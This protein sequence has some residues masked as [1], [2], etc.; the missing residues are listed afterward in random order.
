MVHK[1][2]KVNI[3]SEVPFSGF[4]LSLLLSASAEAQPVIQGKLLQEMVSQKNALL[5]L[6]PFDLSL[7]PVRF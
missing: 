6:S 7:G 2:G 4:K 1:C 5:K 3:I